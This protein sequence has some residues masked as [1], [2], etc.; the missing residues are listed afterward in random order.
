M[1]PEQVTGK[2]HRIDGRTDIYGLGV[3][4]Y[5]LL[6]RTTISLCRLW[7]TQNRG[8]QAQTA[9]A[10]IYDWFDEGFETPDLVDAKQLLATLK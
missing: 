9:L 8:S 7:Q 5:R 1:S 10:K 2:A 6:C 3:V 4:L